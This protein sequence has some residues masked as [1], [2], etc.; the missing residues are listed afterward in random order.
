MHQV[1]DGVSKPGRAELI[2]N[3]FKAIEWALQKAAPGDGVL[4]SGCGSQP[5]ALVGE[6][7]WTINDR[8]V[9]EAWLY[10]NASLAPAIPEGDLEP[11]IYNID[12]YREC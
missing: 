8:D 2:P 9:C 3:R 12:D 6:E 11:G 10:D 5:F 1:L 4:V 7:S